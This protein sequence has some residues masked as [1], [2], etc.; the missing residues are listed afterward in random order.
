[1]KTREID[2]HILPRRALR[3]LQEGS[4][5]GGEMMM[6]YSMRDTVSYEGLQGR[7]GGNHIQSGGEPCSRG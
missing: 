7:R 1:M 4:R 6:N 2:C 5:G 3:D